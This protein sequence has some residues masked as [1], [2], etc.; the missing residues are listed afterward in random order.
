MSNLVVLKGPNGVRVVPCSG[1]RFLPGEQVIGSASLFDKAKLEAQEQVGAGDLVA[2]SLKT[3]GVT[4]KP[5]CG[6]NKRQQKLNR[7]QIV[8]PEWLKKWVK[9]N[10][11]S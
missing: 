8:G 9:K 1:F 7:Y 3:I 6:C 2:A 11:G 4:K 5:G 10:A